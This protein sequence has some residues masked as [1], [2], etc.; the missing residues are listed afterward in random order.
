MFR[1]GLLV[2][3]AQLWKYGNAPILD[4]GPQMLGVGGQE[5]FRKRSWTTELSNHCD[6]LEGTEPVEVCF[7]TGTTFHSWPMSE[8]IT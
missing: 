2:M 3:T 7:A 4:H 6:P 8:G 1:S 5:S